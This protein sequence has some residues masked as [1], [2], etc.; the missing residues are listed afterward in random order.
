M[1]TGANGAALAASRTRAGH[2]VTSIEEWPAHVDVIR[3]AGVTIHS[4]FGTTTTELNAVHLAEVASLRDPFDIVLVVVKG[5]DTR[6]ACELILP[7]L[8]PTSLVVGVQN[9]MTVDDMA[10]I[11]GVERTVGCV[12]EAAAN[13]F[14][15]G[16]VKQQT[17]VWFALGGPTPGVPERVGE[18]AA[19]LS[20]AG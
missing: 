16:V 5:Y 8:T 11:V 17:G 13:M 1:R 3:G 14:E 12:I 4:P 15:P 6:W 18:V 20:P 19:M 9:G 10:D 2:D 7:L